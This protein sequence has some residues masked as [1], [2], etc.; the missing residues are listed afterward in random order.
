M[1]NLAHEVRGHYC[2]IGLIAPCAQLNPC[3]ISPNG[4]FK[5]KLNYEKKIIGS[6]VN[7]NVKVW[8][9]KG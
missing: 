6:N 9:V 7:S 1:W 8:D 4:I 5:I 3:D 2:D